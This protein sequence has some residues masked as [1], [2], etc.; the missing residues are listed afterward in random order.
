MQ[1]EEKKT[2]MSKLNYVNRIR[3]EGRE[4]EESGRERGREGRGREGG[5][6]KG[7]ICAL[8]RVTTCAQRTQGKLKQ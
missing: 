2:G 8:Q 7:K 4:E 6:R 3:E 1:T 5:E